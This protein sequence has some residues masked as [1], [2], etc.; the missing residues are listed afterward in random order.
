MDYIKLAESLFDKLA[1]PAAA[2]LSVWILRKPCTTLVE[3]VAGLLEKRGFKFGWKEGFTVDAP[4]TATAIQSESKKPPGEIGFTTETKSSETSHDV[5]AVTNGETE[6][7]LQQVRDV[8][9]PPIVQEQERLIHEELKKLNLLTDKEELVKIL[10]RHLAVTML[11]ARAEFVYRTI[12]G[13]QIALLRFLNI[14]AVGT[15]AQ[16]LQFY[17]NAKSHFP[18][19]YALYSFEQYLHYLLTNSLI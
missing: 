5:P 7:R 10:V 4:P 13:S 18:E 3:R 8:G 19:V 9:V 16:L 11:W 15:K 14:A 2:C 1:W 12:F 6:S 17:E